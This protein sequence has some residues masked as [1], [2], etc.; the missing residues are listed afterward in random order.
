MMDPK[1]LKFILFVTGII[2]GLF[3]IGT[4]YSCTPKIP[5]KDINPFEV[6]TSHLDHLYEEKKVEGHDV[7][8]VHIYSEYPDYHWV[9]DNDEGIACVDDASRAC[10]FYLRQYAGTSSPEYLDKGIKLLRFL[11]QMQAANGYFYNFIWED[12]SINKTGKTSEAIP[13]WWSWRSLWA[14][15][16]AIKILQ[17]IKPSPDLNLITEIKKHRDALVNVILKEGNFFSTKTDTTSGIIIPTWLPGGS[18]TDQASIMLMG[19]A[20]AYQQDIFMNHQAKRDSVELL[21]QNLAEGIMIMQVNAPGVICDGAFLSWE[22]LWHA[23][24]NVQSYALLSAGQILNDPHMQE[25]PLYEINNFYLKIFAI[26]Y[27][28]SFWVHKV[29]NKI[30]SYNSKDVPQIAYGIRPM[31]WACS[32]AYEVTADEKYKTQAKRIAGWFSGQNVAHALMYDPLTGRGYDGIN[33]TNQIN[34]NSGAESTIEALLTM[35]A[36]ENLDN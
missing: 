29:D 33:A 7:A 32:K 5:G 6:N 13:T 2:T 30:T 1:N 17:E 10:V 9:G 23:Y 18:A 12:G 34:K 25:R 4:F 21:I 19:L 36:I 8:I 26:G 35:Q 27:L 31:V 24:A 14:M 3:V 11:M 22:N 15:G 16:E 28:E 20:L